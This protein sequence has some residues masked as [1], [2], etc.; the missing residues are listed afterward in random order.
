MAEPTSAS[1]FQDLILVVAKKLG[2]A[3]Y[4]VNGNE[5]AQIP[6]DAFELATCKEHV[7]N[8]IRMFL[9]NAPLSGWRWARP[10][11]SVSLWADLAI[12][13]TATAA[14]ATGTAYAVGDKVTDS[15][16]SYVCLVAHTAAALFAT[17][18]AAANWRETYD[19]TAVHSPST[20]LTTITASADLFYPSMEGRSIVVTG[21]D[22]YTIYRYVSATQVTIESTDYWSTDATFSIASN[23]N[24]TLPQTFGGQY[25]GDITYAS[26]TNQITPIRWIG[27]SRIRH[28]RESPTVRTGDPQ[29]A[30]VRRF[31]DNPRRWELVV[32]P[33]PSSLEVV[34][35]PFDLHFDSL[36]ALT[37]LHPAGYAF[38]E[39]MRAACKAV[40]ERD[41]EDVLGGDTQYYRDI[42]LPDAHRIDGRSAPRRLGYCGNGPRHGMNQRNFRYFQSRPTVTT[43]QDS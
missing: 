15:S 12:E 14:W 26:G 9:S 34:E 36:V 5:V 29:L 20:G 19:C 31:P 24:Y 3:Y 18:L 32:Y 43:D 38:D 8:A 27:E 10:V 22:T 11:A 2:V 30:A 40:A 21:Q 39:A 35:F 41:E 6:I 42:V 33:E 16:E 37:D 23:G 4:G 7:Q 13:V 28:L 1:T 17:D 25:T